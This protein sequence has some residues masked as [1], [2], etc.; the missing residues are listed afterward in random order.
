MLLISPFG[1]CV[2]RVVSLYSLFIRSELI[3]LLMAVTKVQKQEIL[4]ELVDSFKKSKSAVFGQ[5]QGTNVKNIRALRKK[6]RENNA[7]FKVARKTLI[8][9]AAKEAGFPEVP[10]S[11]LDGQIG[12]AFSNGDAIIG[13]K[14]LHDFGKDVES[15]KIIGAFFEGKYLDAASAKIIASLP[16]R[17]QLLAQLVGMLK[18]PISGFHGTLHGILS[19]FVRA[20]DAVRQK[21]EATTAA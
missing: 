18:G 13:A 16:G 15:I 21:K 1:R 12:I 7:E 2:T 4:K 17:E 8:A 6:L 20:I 5:Y 10:E 19:G 3:F 14:T 9:L 11:L